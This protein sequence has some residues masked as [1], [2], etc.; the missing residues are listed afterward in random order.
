MTTPPHLFI[1]RLHGR[2]RP[3][4]VMGLDSRI[5]DP[6]EF[7]AE[8]PIAILW[9]GRIGDETRCLRGGR[10]PYNEPSHCACGYPEDL[11]RRVDPRGR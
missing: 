5:Y 1:D 6:F 8:S 11:R 4:Q 10:V 3:H 7:W 9:T 2:P